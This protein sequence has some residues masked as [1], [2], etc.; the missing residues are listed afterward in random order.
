MLGKVKISR[1]KYQIQFNYQMG[2]DK[3]EEYPNGRSEP[4]CV[5]FIV[6]MTGGCFRISL[7]PFPCLCYTPFH[8][9][10]KPAQ[11]DHK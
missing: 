6:S 4:W 9:A 2:A 7:L 3:L 8:A 5:L 10:D 1:A 11:S